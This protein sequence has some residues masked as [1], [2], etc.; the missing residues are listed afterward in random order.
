MKFYYLKNN[1]KIGP[2]SFDQ[3][4]EAKLEDETYVWYKG[5]DK[6]YKLKSLEELNQKLNT[7]DEDSNN[8]EDI[9]YEEDYNETENALDEEDNINYKA[10]NNARSKLLGGFLPRLTNFFIGLTIIIF[11]STITYGLLFS[12]QEFEIIVKEDIYKEKVEEKLNKY[13]V[14]LQKENYY[15]YKKHYRFPIRLYYNDRFVKE[16]ELKKMVRS[17]WSAL[18][19]FK[20]EPD[21]DKLNVKIDDDNFIIEYPLKYTYTLERNRKKYEHKMM[22]YMKID[23]DFKIYYLTAENIDKKEIFY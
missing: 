22:V 2:L 17:S 10:F 9:E 14:D 16:E 13:Y 20:N 19:D 3:L 5:L 6:W 11:I 8:S 12:E 23:S 18:I 4:K 21:F 7:N 15:I 1:E